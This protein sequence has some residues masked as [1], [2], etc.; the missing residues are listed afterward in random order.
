MSTTK[1]II[2][3][4]LIKEVGKNFTGILLILLLIVIGNQFFLVLNESLKFGL[5]NSEIF[6]LLTLKILRDIPI[7]FIFSFTISVTYTLNKLYKNSEILI[8]N[9]SGFGDTKIYLTLQPLIL[10]FV[11]VIFIFVFI[12]APEVKREISNV[13]LN[14]ENRPEF[15]FLKKGEFQSFKNNDITFFSKESFKDKNSENQI[16]GDIFIYSKENKKIIL[17]DKGLQEQDFEAKNF[18]IT[19]FDGNIYDLLD[20]E[21]SVSKFD[22]FSL[23]IYEQQKIINSF[24]KNPDEKKFLDLLRSKNNS[25]FFELLYRVSVVILSF[26]L[27]LFAILI[28]KTNPRNRKNF[29]IGYGLLLFFSYYNLVIYSLKLSDE[30]Q[31]IH[32]GL[33]FL[34]PHLIFLFFFSIIFFLQNKPRII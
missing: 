1:P 27:S 8:L 20:N 23:N 31:L 11:T 29:S 26:L 15:L 2:Q 6:Y 32:S 16:F 13:R 19:L 21:L 22:K 17:A 25:D 34:Y 24:E 3:T 5:L 7:I 14:A 18:Y 33:L 28:S 12:I 10:I 4:Y 30:N 9:S